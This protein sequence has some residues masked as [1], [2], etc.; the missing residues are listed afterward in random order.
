MPAYKSAGKRL[1]LFIEENQLKQGDRLP[2]EKELA[3][4]L[5]I[6]RLTL[7]EAMNALKQDGI[8]YSI[9]GKGT[10]VSCDYNYIANSLNLNE[11]ISEMI[12]RSGYT[13]NTSL[14]QKKIVKADENIAV[15]LGIQAGTDVLM[16]ERIRL[17]DKIPVV[18]SVDY[19]ASKLT[20]D[21]LA[22]TDKNV[23]LYHF[24]EETCGIEIGQCM[25]EIIPAVADKELSEKLSVPL[26]TCLL[27]FIV[28][29]QDIYC[30]PIIYAVEYLRADKF[31]FIINRRR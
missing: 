4:T 28:R 27:K 19:L 11:S 31:K 3:E 10:F 21:F 16:C 22:V 12:E 9:Q 25:T 20:S 30:Q 17:A 18:F 2:A 14:F 23:S 8:I 24:I 29:V 6:S 13:C 26:D 5:E 7:R 15:G 1:L